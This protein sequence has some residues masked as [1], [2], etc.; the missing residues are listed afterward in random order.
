MKKVLIIAY[1]WPPSGGGGVQRWVKFAKYLGDFGWQPIVYVPKNA[2]YS[3]VDASIDQDIPENIEIW[4]YPIFEPYHFYNLFKGKKK[5]EKIHPNFLSEGKKLGWKDKIAVWVRGNIFIPDARFM[6]ILP[7]RRYLRQKLTDTKVDMIISTG[8]PHSVH[9][10]A[11][12]LNSTFKIPWIVDY[13]DPWTQIDYFDEL[14]LTCAAKKFHQYLESKVLDQCDHIITVGKNMALDLEAL[15]KTPKSVITNGYDDSEVK[16]N[17]HLPLDFN[18]TYLGVMNVS[19]NPTSLWQV[20]HD[21]ATEKHTLINE[22]NVKLVGQ[23]DAESKSS[24]KDFRI[25][26]VVQEIGYVSHT[27]ALEYLQNAAILLLVINKTKNNKTILTGKIFEYIASGKPILCIGPKDGDAADILRDVENAT[28]FEYDDVEGIKEYLLDMYHKFNA[29]N[30]SIVKTNSSKY[31]RK[32]L[33]QDLAE[34]M[35][36]IVMNKTT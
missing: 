3:V 20:L 33:T 1:Y 29:G 17:P 32:N 36:K 28:I 10:I 12:N 27:K 15:T 11:Q 4:Q 9:L 30:F 22:L 16:V 23:I 24:I 21:L 34:L 18:I 13:R 25:D 31:S 19:R 2:N 35:N 7:S 6:W 14:M 26:N 8:P 5:T